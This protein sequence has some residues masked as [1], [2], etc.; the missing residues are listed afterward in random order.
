[1]QLP[2]IDLFT[3]CYKD[4]GRSR[5]HTTPFKLGVQETPFGKVPGSVGFTLPPPKPNCN[6]QRSK[7]GTDLRSVS[8]GKSIL[9]PVL[10][11]H[12]WSIWNSFLYPLWKVQGIHPEA[13][14]Y[15][16]TEYQLKIKGKLIILSI[17]YQNPAVFSPSLFHIIYCNHNSDTEQGR[18]LHTM[19]GYHEKCMSYSNPWVRDEQL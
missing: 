4:G 17:I 5:N 1:M 13:H 18:V 10:E 3:S 16:I 6:H 11:T 15:F 7:H 12:M 9:K 2:L 14:S 8:R 19:S